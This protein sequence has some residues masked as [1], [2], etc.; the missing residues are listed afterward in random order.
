MNTQLSIIIPSLSPEKHELSKRA[1]DFCIPSIQQFPYY[2]ALNGE[3]TD[4]PQGQCKAVNRVAKEINSDWLLISNNDMF[5]HPTSIERL[6]YWVE[7]MNLLVA[8]PNLVEPRKGAPP[9]L[10]HNCG[11]L[12]TV[13]DKPD[14]NAEWFFGFVFNHREGENHPD[15]IV[16]DGFNFPLLIRRDVWETVGG[17]DEEYDP[18]GNN[19]DS[20]L[21][22]KIMI[23]GI[24]PKRV[25]SSLVYHFSNT[26][27]T[28]H[29]DHNAYWQKNFKYF[30]EKWGFERAPSPDIWYKPD[31]PMDKLKYKPKWKGYFINKGKEEE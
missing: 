8:C 31:I 5:Y 15:R 25:R 28:F 12:G 18:W 11:G 4:Y 7:N 13:E 1:L 14:F 16:E 26:S 3:G 2:I 24:T 6:L 30:T 22:Y 23:A 17:Y 19:S 27:G 21:Q 10:M 20:D 29:P 9:F